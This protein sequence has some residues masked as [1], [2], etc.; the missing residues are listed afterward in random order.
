[1]F[2]EASRTAK[3]EGL[4][5]DETLLILSKHNVGNIGSYAYYPEGEFVGKVKKQTLDLDERLH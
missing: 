4:S 5:I 3:G 2:E 1:M